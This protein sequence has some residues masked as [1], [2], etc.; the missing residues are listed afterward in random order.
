MS[1]EKVDRSRQAV[2]VMEDCRA[3]LGQVGTLWHPGDG[4][5]YVA[6]LSRVTAGS[7]TGDY[8]LTLVVAQTSYSIF[9]PAPWH[10]QPKAPYGIQDLWVIG[11]LTP[12]V[13]AFQMSQSEIYDQTRQS[14]R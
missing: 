2:L 6:G 4:T 5:Q 7:Y 1:E 3:K 8:V 11:A 10:R 14:P 13:L 9:L 12:L